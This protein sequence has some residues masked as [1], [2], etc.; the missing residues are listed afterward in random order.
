MV[1]NAHGKPFVEGHPGVH[2]SVAHAPGALLC[3]VSGDGDVGVDVELQGRTQDRAFSSLARLARR[4]F[5][6]AEQAEL[7]GLPGEGA[8]RARFL[9][10]WTLKEAYVKALGR[11]IAAAPLSGFSVSLVPGQDMA[12]PHVRRIRLDHGAH[13]SPDMYTR[14]ATHAEAGGHAPVH[15]WHFQLLLLHGDTQA[16]PHVAAVCC[17]C[18]APDAAPLLRCWRVLPGVRDVAIEAGI[19]GEA[20]LQLLAQGLA[21]V[22]T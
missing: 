7:A 22:R 9:E 13:A 5:S 1:S 3:A 21:P 17:P 15:S 12:Q 20:P 11:G 14:A 8:Q 4:Y 10:L 2:F 16:G 6:A 18:A 19:G